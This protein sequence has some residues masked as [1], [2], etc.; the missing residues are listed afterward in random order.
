M[1]ILSISEDGA[2]NDLDDAVVDGIRLLVVKLLELLGVIEDRLTGAALMVDTE[3]IDERFVNETLPV[4]VAVEVLIF[5]VGGFCLFL[6][7]RSL[8]ETRL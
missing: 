6:S 8:V 1:L 7:E 5:D 2:D 4:A 3:G